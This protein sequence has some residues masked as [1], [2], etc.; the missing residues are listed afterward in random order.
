MV[1]YRIAGLTV[2]MAVSGRTAQQA[3]PYA[4]SGT[5]PADIVVSCDPRRIMERSDW[6]EDLDM[7]EYMGSGDSFAW[8]LLDH[9]GFQLH[10]SAVELDGRAYLFSGHC[11]AGKSTHSAK[12]LRLF[13]AEYL[14]DDKPALRRE[15]GVW[16]AYGTPWSGKWDISAN[17]GAPL[18]ALAF[19]SRSEDGENT[20][21]RLK[22]AEALPLLLCQTLRMLR[23]E[24]M[25]RLLDLADM[26]LRE[27]PIWSLACGD[28]D[29][30]ALLSREK[31]QL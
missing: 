14:N 31:M 22:P 20:M 29:E 19:I 23:R 10:A 13:G 15:H 1:L 11:G 3:A 26:L 21:Q 8:Q 25:E 4:A 17:R 2:E 28:N 16:Y 9:D 12:W 18:G 24:R 7:A 27:I 6:I 5:G 30:A